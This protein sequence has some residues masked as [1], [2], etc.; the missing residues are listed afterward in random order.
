MEE[1]KEWWE[2]NAEKLENGAVAV[3]VIAFII[4]VCYLISFGFSGYLFG[5]IQNL[6]PDNGA[7]LGDF[8]GGVIGTLFGGATVV[9]V[10]LTYKSQKAELRETVI[11]AERQR[12]DNLFFKLITVIEE[13]LLKDV[14]VGTGED[15]YVDGSC[16]GYIEK[17]G[18]KLEEHLRN[19]ILSFLNQKITKIEYHDFDIMDYS[20]EL[21]KDEIIV[22]YIE[23]LHIIQRSI[24][25]NLQDKIINKSVATMYQVIM[26]HAIGSKQAFLFGYRLYY[27]NNL[28]KEKGKEKIVKTSVFWFDQ[29]AYSLIEQSDD[30]TVK[31]IMHLP[32]LNIHLGNATHQF[33]THS[34]SIQVYEDLIIENKDSLDFKIIDIKCD[35][36]TL[37]NVDDTVKKILEKKIE[38][39][40]ILRHYSNWK[41]F[42]NQN[43]ELDLQ[44]LCH[45]GFVTT[46]IP[47]LMGIEYDKRRFDFV[48]SL[49]FIRN[50]NM[51]DVRIEDGYST[52]L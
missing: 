9:L 2:R 29:K 10:Y 3:A 34:L 18:I 30:K 33:S 42:F 36:D 32:R 24:D 12:F 17:E 39:G 1:K 27:L 20:K 52:R 22:P 38:L 43:N 44:N 5:N 21:F 25:Q 50:S 49:S 31:K 51:I 14:V 26:R 45:S 16:E 6:S 15:K 11:T 8:I 35:T 19:Y 48:F 13:Y 28:K 41:M 4:M 40:N 46:R 37:L 23:Y 7:K 47:I